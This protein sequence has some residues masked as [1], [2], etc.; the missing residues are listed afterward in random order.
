LNSHL[1][2]VKREQEQQREREMAFRDQ[3]EKT[4]SRV[5]WWIILQIGLLA[6]TCYWQTRHLKHF[7]IAKKLV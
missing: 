5:V 3:S 6:G 7:F 4:N 2:D 1:L